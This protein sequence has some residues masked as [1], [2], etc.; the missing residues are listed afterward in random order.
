MSGFEQIIPHVNELIHLSTDA[1][2]AFGG[3][4]LVARN[5]Q[6]KTVF[7]EIARQRSHW[8]F[9]LSDAMEGMLGA[10]QGGPAQPSGLDT[11]WVTMLSHDS[12]TERLSAL[13]RALTCHRFVI[14][15]CRSVLD[16]DPP[17]PIRLLLQIQIDK[18]DQ[19]RKALMDLA[20]Q[21]GGGGPKV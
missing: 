6:A 12:D 7:F 2:N 5:P 9:E 16:L 19:S 8:S 10:S 1:A 15:R 3:A 4:G 14:D 20:G 13:D 18:A 21:P 11:G 17:S